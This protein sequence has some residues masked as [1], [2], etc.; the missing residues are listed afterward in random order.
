MFT[1]KLRIAAV[2]TATTALVIGGG[3]AWAAVAGTPTATTIGMGGYISHSTDPAGFTDIQDVDAGNQYSLTTAVGTQGV[4]T[5]DSAHGVAVKNGLFSSNLNTN[6]AV[7]WGL[8]TGSACPA[9]GAVPG[10]TFPNLANVPYGHR[11]WLDITKVT[12]DKKVKLLICIL[13][14]R[15][16]KTDFG[17]QPS[18]VQTE[19]PGTDEQLP[20]GMGTRL[21]GHFIK[22]F[23]VFKVIHKDFALFRAQDL[24]APTATPVAGDLPGVQTAIVK[25]P[26]HTTFDYAAWGINANTTNIVACTGLA[27][28]GFTYSRTLAGPAAYIS[29]ACQPAVEA[30][31]ATARI[32]T[33]A[34][35]D[36][37]ALDT[38]E[39]ISGAGTAADP[40]KVAP[41]NSL[42]ATTPAA[43][44]HGTDPNASLVG[45]HLTVELGNAPVS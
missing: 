17:H 39:V 13:K 4:G 33:G 31:Y 19:T 7:Q 9:A 2:T 41:D 3:A 12:K 23:I 28:D 36:P 27:A 24:D 18:P 40:A 42:T 38:T 22:C 26:K 10:T 32:G 16:G 5:C 14:F 15:D 25:L 44:P 8:A 20:D 6:F 37:T 35:Q 30:G 43:F 1:R 45:G 11:V 21:H 29:G 34:S